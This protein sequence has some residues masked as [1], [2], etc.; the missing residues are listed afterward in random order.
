MEEDNRD[1]EIAPTLQSHRSHIKVTP[2]SSN[3]RRR[4]H[5]AAPPRV[6]PNGGSL[7]NTTVPLC[8]SL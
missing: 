4:S 7:Q 6:P 1:L 2:Q 8:A 5:T 3:S